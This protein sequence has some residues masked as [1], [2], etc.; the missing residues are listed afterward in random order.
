[1]MISRLSDVPLTSMCMESISQRKKKKRSIPGFERL[2]AEDPPSLRG[3]I[4]MLARL[5][6]VTGK[7]D[8]PISG[9]ADSLVALTALG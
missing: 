4:V 2:C 6:G 1:M 3:L 5:G 9:A 8:Q 7:H